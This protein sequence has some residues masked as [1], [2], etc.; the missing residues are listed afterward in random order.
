MKGYQIII[1]SI[2]ALALI[3]LG[4]FTTGYFYHGKTHSATPPGE[5]RIDTLVVT[6]PAPAPIIKIKKVPGKIQLDTVYV[7]GHPDPMPGSNGYAIIKVASMDT[8]VPD[9]GRASVDYFFP[10]VNKFDFLFQPA[11]RRDSLIVQ[12]VYRDKIIYKQR[13]YQKD[14]LWFTAGS[15]AA[16]LIAHQAN[17]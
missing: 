13:W 9:C 7:D 5:T 11:P 1:I 8:T 10:P 3:F 16:V 12:T 4:G 6:L 14:W 15:A 17:H 2:L